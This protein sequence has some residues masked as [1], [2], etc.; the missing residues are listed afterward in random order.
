MTIHPLAG[1]PASEDVLID[2]DR[3]QREYYTRKPEFTDRAQRVGFGTS[4][5]RGSSLVGSFNETHVLAITQAI[6]DYRSSQGTN[7]P[8]YI[9]K[10]THALSE[11]AFT[12]ALEVLAANGVETMIDAMPAIRPPP[13]SPTPSSAL[14]SAE[15]QASRTASLSRPRTIRRK[16]AASNITRRAADPPIQL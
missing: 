10:D 15:R 9:G 7:G 2:A 13:P 12:T 3:L 14:I 11:V 1:K 6:C 16:M 4:G 8:L 5:H